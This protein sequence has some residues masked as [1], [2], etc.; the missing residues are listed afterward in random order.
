VSQRPTVVCPLCGAQVDHLE[1]HQ[2][3]AHRVPAVAF[4]AEPQAAL[5]SVP[6]SD[7]ASPDAAKWIA[8]AQCPMCFKILR[9]EGLESHMAGHPKERRPRPPL[10]LT[11][12]SP[13]PSAS[14]ASNASDAPEP[15]HGEDERH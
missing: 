15:S 11:R 9:R 1:H 4:A 13:P 3:Q 7:P 5:R 10:L 2:R 6:A 14:D 8:W 12:R